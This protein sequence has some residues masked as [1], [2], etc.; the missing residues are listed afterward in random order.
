MNLSLSAS[1]QHYR[2][3][4]GSW[5]EPAPF[6]SAYEHM[7]VLPQLNN[8]GSPFIAC[9]QRRTS[10]LVPREKPS[11]TRALELFLV[12]RVHKLEVTQPDPSGIISIYC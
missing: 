1:A 10:G 4:F 12:C 9:S 8:A 11:H 3:K 7:F 6:V 5:A 2:I